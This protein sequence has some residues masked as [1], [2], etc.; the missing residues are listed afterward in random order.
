VAAF[1]LNRE[2]PLVSIGVNVAAV[3][4]A[5]RAYLIIPAML[6][7]MCFNFLWQLTKRKDWSPPKSDLDELQ[8]ISPASKHDDLD[9]E[10]REQ[11]E[12]VEWNLHCESEFLFS[13]SDASDLFLLLQEVPEDAGAIA[14]MRA[15]YKMMKGYMLTAQIYLGMAA[16]KLEQ[17]ESLFTWRDVRIT[18]LATFAMFMGSLVIYILGF[19]FIF[20][21]GIVY[22]VSMKCLLCCTDSLCDHVRLLSYSFAI[23]PLKR[24]YRAE[25]RIFGKDCHRRQK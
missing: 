16:E 8:G 18:G 21:M 1:V 22:E 23:Q 9:S 4:F 5:Y 7:F 15:S 2:N 25:E 11:E 20:A 14:K 3:F 12:M 24:H 17:A 6:M 13:D 19:K 10:Q